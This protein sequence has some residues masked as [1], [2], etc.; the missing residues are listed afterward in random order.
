[1]ARR[2]LVFGGLFLGF[3]GL[4]PWLFADIGVSNLLGMFLRY[5]ALR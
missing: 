2:F 1:M 5:Y 3:F 4:T